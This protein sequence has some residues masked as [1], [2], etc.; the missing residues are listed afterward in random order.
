MYADEDDEDDRNKI[1][2]S[3]FSILIKFMAFSKLI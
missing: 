3:Q 1:V 2:A